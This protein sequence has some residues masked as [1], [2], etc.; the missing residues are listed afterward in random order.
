M[1]INN[2]NNIS[3][4]TTLRGN[5]KHPKKQEAFSGT[6]HSLPRQGI[7]SHFVEKTKWLFLGGGRLFDDGAGVVF[8]VVAEGDFGNVYTLTYWQ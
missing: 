2:N 5:Q 6:P 1:S 4:S 3:F 8:G 7:K